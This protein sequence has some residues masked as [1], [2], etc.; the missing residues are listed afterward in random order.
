VAPVVAAVV[1]A[2][3]ATPEAVAAPVAVAAVEDD[4]D[5]TLDIPSP[6]VTA[7]AMPAPALDVEATQPIN[8]TELRAAVVTE[9]PEVEATAAA[10][11]APVAAPAAT[12]AADEA[13]KA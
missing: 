7:G 13:P 11:E 2:V 9:V 8:I 12:P 10:P 4:E 3:V 1:E 5:A 6:F